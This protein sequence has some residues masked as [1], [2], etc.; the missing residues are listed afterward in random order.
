MA[1][2]VSARGRLIAAL[3]VPTVADAERLAAALKGEVGVFKIG[4]QLAFAGGLGLARE[5]A[6]EGEAVFLDLKLLDI[7]NTVAKGVESVLGLGARYLTVHGY[8]HAMRAAAA[9]RGASPLKLIAIGVLTSLDAAEL[10]AAGYD[11]PI[12]E[13]IR[14]RSRAAAAAGFDA[15][16]CAPGEAALVKAVAPSLAAVTPGIR[17]AGSDRAEQKRAATPADAIRAGADLLVVGRPITGA[18]DP[19]SAARAIVDEIAAA[20]G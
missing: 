13:L 12:D 14:L 16:V 15:V 4:Y 2:P 6:E 11:R 10:A 7:D 19:R 5:L 3:D 8:P 17:P 9:A 20:G 18:P 1:V